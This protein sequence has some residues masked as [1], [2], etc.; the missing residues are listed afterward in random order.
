[1]NPSKQLTIKNTV[2]S[3]VTEDH[4]LKYLAQRAFIMYMKSVFLS[5]DAASFAYLQ[6]HAN[7][8]AESFGL[9]QIPVIKFK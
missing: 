4:D 1:M 6:E 9:V 3:F 8:L 5:T 2:Q 7:D